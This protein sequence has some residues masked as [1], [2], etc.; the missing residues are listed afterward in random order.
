[1]YLFFT[2]PCVTII[3][4]GFIIIRYLCIPVPKLIK[5]RVNVLITQVPS[6]FAGC[7]VN[8]FVWWMA[9]WYIY[10]TQWLSI[11]LFLLPLRS[12]GVFGGL[13]VGCRSHGALSYWCWLSTCSNNVCLVFLRFLFDH[14]LC[15]RL[16][17]TLKYNK[18]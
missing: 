18:S 5:V 4:N 17:K 10:S 14:W 1:M 13:F 7:L 11:Y 9:F 8:G 12:L 15:H 2:I 3:A 16:Q 6:S